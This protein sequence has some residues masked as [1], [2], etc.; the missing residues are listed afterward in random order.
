MGEAPW[1]VN[2]GSEADLI[3]CKMYEG[4]G[5]E[6]RCTFSLASVRFIAEEECPPFEWKAGCYVQIGDHK[7]FFVDLSY[8][9]LLTSW[10]S[11]KRR[12]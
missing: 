11:W 12:H 5:D 4:I 3:E 8:D 9:D 2:I 7:G 6:K 1:F 10:K